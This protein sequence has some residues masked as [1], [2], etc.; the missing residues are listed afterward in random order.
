MYIRYNV[1]EEDAREIRK[2]MKFKEN[3]KYYNKLL[4][5]ALRGEGKK[6][7]EIAEITKYHHKR[8][9]QLVAL[10][11]NEGL[12]A[13]A[14]DGRKGGNNRKLSSEEEK[15]ILESFSKKAQNGQIVSV[16]K[17]EEKFEAKLAEKGDSICKATVY[18]ILHRNNWRRV[19]PRG[20]HPKKAK[21]E[22]IE[23]SKKLKKNSSR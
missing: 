23:A 8:V 2:A 14:S 20:K 18:N 9:S 11:C 12:Q 17:I 21:D 6:N 22:D 4:A 7:R 16:N 15:E 13:L 19:M 5:V 10:Y 1:T 3:S